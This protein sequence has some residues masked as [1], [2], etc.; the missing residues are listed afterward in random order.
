AALDETLPAALWDTWAAWAVSDE[1]EHAAAWTPYHPVAVAPTATP[2]RTP[3][4]SPRPTPTPSPALSATP[5]AEP[6]FTPTGLG[7]FAPQVIVR[8]APTD[9]AVTP[10]NTALAPGSL[11]SATPRAEPLPL[12]EG[13]TGALDTR[14]TA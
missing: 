14:E 3:T 4:V 6:R 10:T 11:P 12:A 7:N 1:A 9:A 8:Q 13:A 5:T 2:T